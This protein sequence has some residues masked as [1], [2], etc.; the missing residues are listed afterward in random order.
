[1]EKSQAW[2][3]RRLSPTVRQS[4]RELSDRPGQSSNGRRTTDTS[5]RGLEDIIFD[6][7]TGAGWIPG[8]SGD[9]DREVCVDL[10]Q[11]SAFLKDYPTGHG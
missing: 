4:R 3:V 10:P 8:S 9:Y 7:M 11:L 5:E 2:H 6:A 1:M